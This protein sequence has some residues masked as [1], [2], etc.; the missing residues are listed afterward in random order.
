MTLGWDAHISHDL[1]IIQ[2]CIQPT[3]IWPVHIHFLQG[4]S[5][6][7]ICTGHIYVLYSHGHGRKVQK[8]KRLFHI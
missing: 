2:L 8:L 6:C 3:Y 5:A 7:Y 1:N 4:S